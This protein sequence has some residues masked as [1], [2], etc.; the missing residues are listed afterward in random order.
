M[1]WII[2][3]G[4][5]A[6]LIKSIST[7]ALSRDGMK[8]LEAMR[9]EAEALRASSEWMWRGLVLSFS[10]VQNK[11]NRVWKN[12]EARLPC[13]AFSNV[14]AIHDEA[15]RKGF[16]A[17]QLH[18]VGYRYP[19]RFCGYLTH[20]VQIF[21]AAGGPAKAATD[22]LGASDTEKIAFMSQFKGISHKYARNMWMDSHPDSL[23]KAFAIDSNILQ[24]VL[25]LFN[26]VPRGV[27]PTGIANSIRYQ[28]AEAHLAEISHEAN[29]TTW[30]ADR[31]MYR[32]RTAILNDMSDA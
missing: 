5:R 27:K 18:G 8:H 32:F 31:L 4:H 25:A 3:Q 30:E 17:E 12:V 15:A 11:G 2:N 13:I 9:G 26:Q 14:A 6:R 20:A 10:T 7:H 24:I 19:D 1:D 29:V 16:L 23:K 21:E 22:L 28:E